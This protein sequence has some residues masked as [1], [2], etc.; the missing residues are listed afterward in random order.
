MQ[1]RVNGVS[2]AVPAERRIED[3]HTPPDDAAGTDNDSGN[4]VPTDNGHRTVSDADNDSND[5]ALLS[6][7]STNN[8]SDRSRALV[9]T[10]TRRPTDVVPDALAPMREAIQQRDTR[11]G[12]VVTANIQ[13]TLL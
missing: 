9:E 12:K 11:D 5:D 10:A 6:R 1:D 4:R 13:M 2:A 8:L 3:Q 7:H